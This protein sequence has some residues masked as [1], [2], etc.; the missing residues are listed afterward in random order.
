MP[1]FLVVVNPPEMSAGD[2][3]PL[4]PGLRLS[5]VLL[6]FPNMERR[7]WGVKRMANRR[8]MNLSLV[9]T[10]ASAFPSHPTEYRRFSY[11]SMV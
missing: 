5:L 4:R 6:T 1:T 3:S 2:Q 10:P 9:P 11:T 8:P 7:D